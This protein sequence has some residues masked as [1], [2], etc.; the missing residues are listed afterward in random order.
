MKKLFLI[1]MIAFTASNSF[2]QF[3]DSSHLNDFIRD[4]IKD[5][6]PGKI[7]ATDLQRALLG[8]S[9]LVPVVTNDTTFLAAKNTEVP[10]ASAVKKYITKTFG[11]LTISTGNTYVVNN[12]DSMLALD[13]AKV[14]DVAVVADS[15]KTYILK[16]TPATN[17]SNWVQIVTPAEVQAFNHRTANVLPE[18]GDYNHT[19]IT[20][21][22]SLVNLKQDVITN[23]DDSVK[24]AKKS[25]SILVFATQYQ[26]SLKQNK[27]NYIGSIYNK[28]SWTDLSD[29]T[30]NG[31]TP[32]IVSNKLQFTGGTGSF[33][34][35][36]DY[37]RY[38]ALEKWTITARIVVGSV[39]T[40]TSYGLGIGLRSTNVNGL[41]NLSAQVGLNTTNLGHLFIYAGPSNNIVASST[42][43]LTVST[44]DSIM[45]ILQRNG[46][47]VTFT[48]WNQT[49]K[50]LPISLSYSYIYDGS[51]TIFSPNTG[52][53]AVFNFGGTQTL[54]SISI[55]SLI[56]KNIEV[57]FV[58]DSKTVGYVT[59]N[60]NTRFSSLFAKYF[61]SI[62][63]AGG[64]DKTADV[65][66]RVQEIID[67]KPTYC[68]LNIGRNDIYYGVSTATILA[69]YDTIVNRLTSAGIHVLHLLPLYETSINQSV[70][71]NH[72]LSTYNAADVIDSHL[73]D[74]SGTPSNVLGTDNVHPNALGNQ[75]I[76]ESLMR[77]KFFNN[78]GIIALTALPGSGS[79]Y[80]T[81]TPGLVPPTNG[82]LGYLKTDGTWGGSTIIDSVKNVNDTLS[83][84]N[85]GTPK[86]I[87]T[88]DSLLTLDFTVGDANA[89][90]IGDS[91]L[92][93][94]NF[95][96]NYIEAY[97]EGEY[98]HLRNTYGIGTNLDTLFFHPA[99]SANEAVSIKI[100]KRV[101]MRVV[102]LKAWLT[103]PTNNGGLTESP[104][105]T[106]TNTSGAPSGVF[107]QTIA[108]ATN[109][110]LVWDMTNSSTQDA[111]AVGFDTSNVNNNYVS[112][113]TAAWVCELYWFGGNIIA[114][115][116]GTTTTFSTAF[117]P[118]STGRLRLRRNGSTITG[119][120]STDS[121][122]TWTLAHTYTFTSSA[123]LYIKA[124]WPVSSTSLVNANIQ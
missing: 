101:R 2:A 119:E 34:Q 12:Q 83:S 26:N 5:R 123:L 19:Q 24:Y 117:S 27:I 96:N 32:T 63:L 9:N 102:D 31:T 75:K 116:G 118:S 55:T 49:T 110:S 33:T 54:D 69:N 29:F 50:S 25:D 15:S 43:V 44:G 78:T 4:T 40:S 89:P 76:F 64:S 121:G 7:T 8:I 45:E 107:P 103:F 70:L 59:G 115:D 99:F 94:S 37:S 10:S 88:V 67:V 36:L 11:N 42:S 87:M 38:T 66:N 23:L 80:N 41:Y 46:D 30:V 60:F 81:T 92:K 95:L 51:T 91:I 18:A 120:Y 85:K 93:N 14:S 68:V 21:L 113:S 105:H 6:R 39:N 90:Q 65:L 109:K 17:L 98:Q 77:S 22:D 73:A 1:L 108:S 58:G 28:N 97:R 124:S 111:V 82:S 104:A 16:D 3:T 100:R 74:Y 84:Y 48:A 56:P 122:V 72:I 35:S 71:T 13:T 57:A 86:F 47:I 79:Y 53:F 112:G 61:N 52:R 20:G 62:T 106:F 114:R